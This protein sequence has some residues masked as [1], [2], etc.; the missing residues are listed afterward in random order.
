MHPKFQTW[1]QPITLVGRHVKLRPLSVEDADAMSAILEPDLF[2]YTIS[3]PDWK[4]QT[5]IRDHVLRLLSNSDRVHFFIEDSTGSAAGHTAYLDIR[6]ADR[7]LEI[8][9]TV[10]GKRFHGTSVNVESKLLLMSHAF[11]T[12]GAVRVQLKTDAR[13]LRSQAAIEG[14]GAKKE[15]VLRSYQ[16]NESGYVRDTVVY[17]VISSEWS[18]VKRHIERRIEKKEL[19]ARANHES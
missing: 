9:A 3:Q 2:T 17:S 15:G 8:G 10:I 1:V 16:T 19:A 11:E 13:N 14:L 7:A 12:L 5:A 4:S 18:T 6:Q